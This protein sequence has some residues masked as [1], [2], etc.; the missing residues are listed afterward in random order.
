NLL[1]ARDG[2][3]KLSDFGLAALAARSRRAPTHGVRDPGLRGFFKHV[4]NFW[5]SLLMLRVR[6]GARRSVVVRGHP[7]RAP[8]GTAPLRRR[9]HPAHVPEDPPARLRVPAL[10]LPP[11]A[12][13]SSPST[14]DAAFPSPPARCSTKSPN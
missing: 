9:Q 14:R 11:S 2:A 6:R 3:L 8:S 1:L 12:T 10:G 7:L 4:V 5:V 13:T